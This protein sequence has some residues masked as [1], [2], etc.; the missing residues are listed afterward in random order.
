MGPRTLRD[1]S[2]TILLMKTR[3]KVGLKMPPCLL[4]AVS[5]IHVDSGC[6]VCQVLGDP[7]VHTTPYTIFP[8]LFVR[9]L[10][11]CPH[12]QSMLVILKDILGLLG[13]V[14]HLVFSRMSA[15]TG[16]MTMFFSRCRTWRVLINLSMSLPTQLVRVIGR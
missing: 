16:V 7:L 12:C 8:D 9:L 10:L 15:C 4:E 1:M 6:P 14:G 2:L 11:V 5:S 3:N 13:S